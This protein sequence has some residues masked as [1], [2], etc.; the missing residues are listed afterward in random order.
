MRREQPTTRRAARP[1]PRRPLPSPRVTSGRLCAQQA[2]KLPPVC[3]ENY[4]PAASRLLRACC[5]G[6]DYNA[7]A[8]R[9]WLR[10]CRERFVH[11]SVPSGRP[12]GAGVAPLRALALCHGEFERRASSE[13]S[14]VGLAGGART[15]VCAYARSGPRSA[16]SLLASHSGT[17]PDLFFHFLRR[18][19]SVTTRR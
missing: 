6:A 17:A 5:A 3:R 18:E 15:V 2:L 19:R 10:R 9:A 11:S 1:E 8:Q 14:C 12:L 13:S 16:P 4:A 7:C